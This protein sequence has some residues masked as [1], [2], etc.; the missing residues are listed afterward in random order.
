[1][2][3]VIG[4]K[5]LGWSHKYTHKP[6]SLLQDN[7]PGA[8]VKQIIPKGTLIR[9]YEGALVEPPLAPINSPTAGHYVIEL[10]PPTNGFWVAYPS[11][12]NVLK[13][14]VQDPKY[15][16][17]LTARQQRLGWAKESDL[18]RGRLVNIAKGGLTDDQA[19]RAHPFK[20]IPIE[21]L[22]LDPLVIDQAA[23]QPS[24]GVPWWVLLIGLGVV[25]HATKRGA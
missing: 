7:A 10:A 24:S 5:T 20:P 9:V 4:S 15:D 17:D 25:Y 16:A 6:I 14:L 2:S 21:A 13:D 12:L 23:S 18:D 8:K 22:K 3:E 1:M 19:N 11:E